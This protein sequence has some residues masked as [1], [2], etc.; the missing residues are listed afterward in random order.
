MTRRAPSIRRNL[1]LASRLRRLKSEPLDADTQGTMTTPP[2]ELEPYPG[3]LR[4][5][6]FGLVLGIAFLTI[7]MLAFTLGLGLLG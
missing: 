7:A 4:F 6:L 1:I 5:A 2:I 3:T